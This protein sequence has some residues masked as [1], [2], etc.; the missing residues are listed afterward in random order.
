MTERMRIGGW[1]LALRAARLPR[2]VQTISGSGHGQ[3]GAAPC[4]PVCPVVD[5]NQQLPPPPPL[6]AM[7]RALLPPTGQVVGL[8]PADHFAKQEQ[9]SMNAPHT[10][11]PAACLP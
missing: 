2:L 6:P 9:S 5:E 11:H 8:P 10:V 7:K 1:F 4:Q 3:W